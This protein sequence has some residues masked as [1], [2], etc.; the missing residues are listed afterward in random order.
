VRLNAGTGG[1][2]SLGR[3]LDGC[4]RPPPPS[5]GRAGRGPARRGLG[6]APPR[7]PPLQRRGRA[8]PRLQPRRLWRLEA[9]LSDSAG[10]AVRVEK[11]GAVQ[12]RKAMSVLSCLVC[13][14]TRSG[15]QCCGLFSLLGVI[16]MSLMG[17]LLTWQWQYIHG[18][19]TAEQASHGASNA[20]A[21]AGIYGGITLLCFVS[22]LYHKRADAALAGA[23][24]AHGIELD[25][26]SEQRRYSFLGGS[27][28]GRS[29]P[30][31]TSLR[32]RPATAQ[33]AFA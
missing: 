25:S 28:S 18:F 2:G 33:V 6:G 21:A 11:K 24:G 20:F 9:K 15:S 26:L 29:L 5:T 23:N 7:G 27:D 10:A 3:Q 14:L 4:A 16:F 17:G 19:Y 12:R 22:L 30:E 1:H 13:C 8:A 31:T 32:Q